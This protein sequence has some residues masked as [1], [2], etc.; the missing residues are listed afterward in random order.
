MVVFSAVEERDLRSWNSDACSVRLG[1][2]TAIV[3]CM[4]REFQKQTSPLRMPVSKSRRA[5]NAERRPWWWCCFAGMEAR[6]R[7]RMMR[8]GGGRAT[9]CQSR[10]A[11]RWVDG[12]SVDV[13]R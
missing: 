11:M 7:G 10:A 6:G 5:G 8:M 4:G 12:V 2:W 1:R 9:W 3:M 13:Q